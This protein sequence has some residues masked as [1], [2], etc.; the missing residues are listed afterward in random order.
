MSDRGPKVPVDCAVQL[1]V[2]RVE[3]HQKRNRKLKL[4]KTFFIKREKRESFFISHEIFV[5]CVWSYVRAVADKGVE[6]RKR[7]EKL[8]KH[9][10][11]PELE[12]YLF[13]GVFW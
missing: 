4:R 5:F 3:K 7:V 2:S 11:W 1:I 9:K 13:W 10:K 12:Q 6:K 8:M